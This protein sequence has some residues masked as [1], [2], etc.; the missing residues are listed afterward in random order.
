MAVVE[1]RE[2]VGVAPLDQSHQV[3]VGESL[4]RLGC[5][6][7][8]HLTPVR[9][10]ARIGSSVRE[11]SDSGTV[12][13]RPEEA[14]ALSASS[15]ARLYCTLVGAALVIAGIIGFFYSS[16]FDTGVAGVRGDTDEVFGIL[17][18]NGWHNLVHIA[19]GLLA[20]AVAGSP[21]GARTY[22][23]A[24]GLLY[25]V[26]AIW[27]F[28]DSDGILLGAVPVNDERQ[29]PAPDPRPGRPRCRRGDSYGREADPLAAGTKADAE[30]KA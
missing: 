23:L 3:F 25:V 27:G 6:P 24:V 19:L 28:A 12:R 11:R 15:P 8:S 9:S 2:R 1:D 22:C 4:Q 5:E 30:A 13:T 21:S 16:G 29:P 18:V 17:G 26:L 7:F 10:Q 14:P 20:L